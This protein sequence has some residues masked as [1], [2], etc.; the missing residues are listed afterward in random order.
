VLICPKIRAG[1][2]ETAGLAGQ[3]MFT[4]RWASM[5]STPVSL[6]Y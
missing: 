2:D 5:K 1:P 3:S 6:A 4:T